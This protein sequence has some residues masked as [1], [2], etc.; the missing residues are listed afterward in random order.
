MR[1]IVKKLSLFVVLALLTAI[2]IP[3]QAG[4]ATGPLI[5]VDPVSIDFGP[6][7]V[8]ESSTAHVVTITNNGDTDLEI[9]DIALTGTF[10][11]H[12]QIT[13][14]TASHSTLAPGASAT[15]SVQFIPLLHGTK[16]AYLRIDHNNHTKS[17]F[18]VDLYG[19][20]ISPNVTDLSVIKTDVP[21]PVYAGGELTYTITVTNNGPNPA[22]DLF[23][24][25]MYPT[26]AFTTQ[27]FIP[28]QGTV[29]P[30][31]PQWVIDILEQD[32]GIFGLPPGYS[33]LTWDAGSLASGASASLIIVATVDPDIQIPLE[34]P[35]FNR[36]GA[37]SSSHED[38]YD[39]NISEIYTDVLAAPVPTTLT[40]EPDEATNM[41]P[42]NPDHALTLTVLDQYGQGIVEIVDLSSANGTLAISEI[43]TDASGVAIFNISSSVAMSDTITATSRTVPGLS[44]TAT[45]TWVSSGG[46][47]PS[48]PPTTTPPTTTPPTTEPTTTPPTTEPTTTPPTTTTT[49]QGEKQY[50]TVDFL[51]RITSV[52][53]T[54]GGRPLEDVIAYSPDNVHVLEIKAG[55]KAT[56]SQGNAVT[57]ITIREAEEQQLPVNIVLA[58]KA[59]NITPSGT[60]FDRDVNLSLGF[61]AGE[62]PDDFISIGMA[63]Y[64][65]DSGWV[66]LDS[67]RN[68]VA[69][70]ENMTS[71][72]NHLT[73]F[74][75]LVEIPVEDTPSPP[76]G[77]GSQPPTAASF[78]LSNLSIIPSEAKTWKGLTFVS[79]YGEDAEITL[80]V[81]NTGGQSGTYQVFLLLN[82]ERVDST[83]VTVA[84]GETQNVVFNVTGNEPGIYTVQI[85]E[86]TG[87]FESSFWI[88]WWL[89]AGFAVALILLIW[90]GF[91]LIRKQVRG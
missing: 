23:G 46:G 68:Q 50:F 10:T 22:D 43:T 2:L 83:T 30:S 15:V 76:D 70:A 41:L 90:L 87:E 85:G 18:Y 75:I 1:L 21:D 58:G 20:G 42:G 81:T 66:H 79:R 12:F 38:N 84:T 3:A 62:L 49:G 29:I 53:A 19:T 13:A 35:I 39:N 69:G 14:D 33:Y 5:S 63:Y 74:A 7:M 51:G 8:G 67:V 73:V 47:G 60:S 71:A 44:A 61:N 80:D 24:F 11:V 32:F 52:E 78:A 9:Y 48:P 86:L 36:G 55:T 28:S 40:L 89:I 59:Y 26:N 56:D 31:L 77:N 82:G 65:P 88:N 54:A 25:D 16:M 6:V 27:S 45:K 17:P 37:V 57:Y 72:F 64:N 4:A 91:Y 34:T